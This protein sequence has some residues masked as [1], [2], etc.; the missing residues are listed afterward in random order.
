M[1]NFSKH[2]NGFIKL[3]IIAI[4]VGIIVLGGI[5]Y[6][7]FKF[8]QKPKNNQIE[9]TS[10]RQ[11]TKNQPAET[12]NQT[13]IFCPKWEDTVPPN[14][15]PEGIAYSVVQK[16]FYGSG[17]KNTQLPSD[18][19]Q[20]TFRILPKSYYPAEKSS[21]YQGGLY[22]PSGEG[23]ILALGYYAKDK[24][25][26]YVAGKILSEADPAT[27]NFVGEDKYAP[28][29]TPYILDKNHI[30]AGGEIVDKA[31][32]CTFTVLSKNWSKD[33][34]QVYNQYYDNYGKSQQKV[35]ADADPA[36]FR[37][38][39][40]DDRFAQDKIHVFRFDGKTLAGVDPTTFV[41]LSKDFEKSQTQ[42]FYKGEVAAD[43]DAATFA[44][45]G[46]SGFFKDAHHLY[47][48]T[49]NGE[50]GYTLKT[51]SPPGM[52]T[53]TFESIRGG[54]FRDKNNVYIGGIYEGFTQIKNAD[55][56]TFQILNVCMSVE[57]SAGYY[58]KDKNYV[59][60]GAA[61][62][63]GADPST[64][65]YVGQYD[66]NPGGMP[67]SSGIGKDKNCIY[68]RD[69]KLLDSAGMCVKPV[70]CTSSSLVSNPS[71]CGIQGGLGEF[72]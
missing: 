58:A 22:L 15:L 41:V 27:F 42:V 46:S 64:F 23:I 30:W 9:N 11:E 24:N 43:A 52:D 38:V 17:F 53:L 60:C 1:K 25:H 66:D 70:T 18:V 65:E 68:R 57:K 10:Q 69:K 72:Q 37:V 56:A 62:I 59:Y 36:T 34:N 40:G 4:I 48:V 45:V 12:Q 35:V 49:G 14:N 54:Y 33:K 61:I 16:Y 8:Q 5:G 39:T 47:F 21:A 6:G 29:A 13:S 31:D 67:L 50:I 28:L 26:V 63:A 2:Q 20:S 32:S 3:P 19:D 44:P 55:P 71:S 51:V 7:F